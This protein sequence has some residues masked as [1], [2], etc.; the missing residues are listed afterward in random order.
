MTEEKAQELLGLMEKDEAADAKELL[1]H[2]ED[3]AGG[4]MT[5][6]YAE[7]PPGLTA[8]QA[9][10]ELRRRY[11]G[12]LDD[13][14]YAYVTDTDEHI[15]GVVSLWGLVVAEPGEP[16]DAFMETKVVSVL[17]DA[18]AEQAGRLISKYGLLEIPVVDSENRLLGVVTIDD[19]MDL[20]APDDWRGRPPDMY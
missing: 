3:S 1:A 20:I 4:I 16:L 13:F 5:N 11:A 6:E 12:E 14:H 19:A 8:G 18:P 17:P 9:L 7:L 10:V 15:L 2:D